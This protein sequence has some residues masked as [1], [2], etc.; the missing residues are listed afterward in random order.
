MSCNL[1]TLTLFT[2]K[3]KTGNYLM[4]FWCL[5]RCKASLGTKKIHSAQTNSN[6][7]SFHGEVSF[8]NLTLLF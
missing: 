3:T 4:F 1:F 7:I 8:N 6:Y 2:N 5:I